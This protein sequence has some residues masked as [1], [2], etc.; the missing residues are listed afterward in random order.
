MGDELLVRGSGT[1][2]AWGGCFVLYCF[3]ILFESV[4]VTLKN[5]CLVIDGMRG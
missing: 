4:V 1:W 3:Q 2:R 5:E